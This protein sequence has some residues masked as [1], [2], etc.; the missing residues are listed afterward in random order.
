MLSL[1]LMLAMQAASQPAQPSVTPPPL[2]AVD[3]GPIEQ[4][5]LGP[6]FS[7]PFLCYEHAEGELE[8]AGDA[9]GS[10]CL[11]YGCDRK[12]DI[13]RLYRTDGAT[14]EDWWSVRPDFRPA[15]SRSRQMSIA[16][17]QAAAKLAPPRSRRNCTAPNS[18]LP[19]APAARR[20]EPVTASAAMKAR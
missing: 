11:I 15:S 2:A 1:A 6:I 5:Q 9:L 12:P 17:S 19:M 13:M 10:D 3:Q 16:A 20:G 4:V 7:K 8:Y 14:N 18:C